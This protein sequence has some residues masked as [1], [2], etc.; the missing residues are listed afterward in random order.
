MHKK[1]F[2]GILCQ[3]SAFCLLI[4]KPRMP[5]APIRGT[6]KLRA[7]SYLRFTAPSVL[8]LSSRQVNRGKKREVCKPLR[9]RFGLHYSDVVLLQELSRTSQQ[10]FNY[11]SL[12]PR[13]TGRQNTPPLRPPRRG[14][15]YL[16]I[17]RPLRPS[18]T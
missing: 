3:Q 6:L 18:R 13:K 4:Q 2:V 11:R 5:C 16:Q 14:H 1:R 9:T 8:L 15:Q 10:I 12:S 17:Y 7:V